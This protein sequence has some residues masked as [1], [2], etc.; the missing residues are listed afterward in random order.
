LWEILTFE[1]VLSYLIDCRR[2][3][4]I[5]KIITN[6][7]LPLCVDDMAPRRLYVNYQNIIIQK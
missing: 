7:S 3:K 1:D 6:L 2:N 4:L 5:N